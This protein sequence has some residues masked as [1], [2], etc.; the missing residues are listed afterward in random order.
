MKQKFFLR[1]TAIAILLS[2]T[3]QS[4]IYARE[5]NFGALIDDT[6]P[7]TL[8]VASPDAAPSMPSNIA[9]VSPVSVMLNTPPIGDQDFSKFLLR[10]GCRICSMWYIIIR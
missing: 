3:F 8:P 1:T 4:L 6:K 5:Y 10:L 9:N 2:F 7:S